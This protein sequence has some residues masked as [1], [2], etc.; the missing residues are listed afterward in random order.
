MI[1]I[2]AFNTAFA[3]AFGVIGCIIGYKI[4]T[5]RFD[6]MVDEVI[7]ATVDKLARDGYIQTRGH[8]EDQEILKWYERNE[9]E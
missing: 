8:G 2:Y 6:R 9:D 7:S 4:G 5:S 3:I 1:E